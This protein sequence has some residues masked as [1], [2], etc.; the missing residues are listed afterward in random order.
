MLWG[1]AIGLI[2]GIV[3]FVIGCKSIKPSFAFVFVDPYVLKHSPDGIYSIL[4]AKSL[5]DFNI[6]ES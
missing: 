3:F 4:Y 1:S 6:L 5:Y 2:L